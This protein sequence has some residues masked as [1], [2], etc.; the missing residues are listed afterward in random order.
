M[1][2]SMVIPDR[3]FMN[4]LKRLD[5]RLDCYFEADHGHFVVTYQRDIGTTEHSVIP[6]FVIQDDEG[7][8]RQPDQRDMLLLHLGDRHIEGQSVRDHLNHV[9]NYMADYR[10]K[11]RKQGKDMIRDITKDDKNQLM[12]AFAKLWGGGKFNSMFRRIIPKPKGKVF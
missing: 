9:T 3:S 12:S 6:L 7:E 8:F 5:K 1:L 10:V 2:D 11:I 4:D